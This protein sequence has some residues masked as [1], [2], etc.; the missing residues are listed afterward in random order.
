MASTSSRHSAFVKDLA[1]FSFPPFIP[2]TPKPA[3]N[4]NTSPAIST[5]GPSTPVPSDLVAKQATRIN[6]GLHYKQQRFNLLCEES[7]GYSHLATELIS[8]MG[9]VSFR[10][11]Y[12][13]I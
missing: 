1:T 5:K 10:I 3:L 13:V 11:W 6:T 2:A 8:A 9:P 4:D 12:L 7:K